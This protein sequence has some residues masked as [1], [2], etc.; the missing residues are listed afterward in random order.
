M[1]T[2]HTEDS[3]G[4]GVFQYFNLIIFPPKKYMQIVALYKYR[5]GFSTLNWEILNTFHLIA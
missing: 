1:S 4:H 3:Q 2:P 5:K